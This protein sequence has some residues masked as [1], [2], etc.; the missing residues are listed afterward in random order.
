MVMGS[1]TASRQKMVAAGVPVV[2]VTTPIPTA[3]EALGIAEDIGYPVM[4][5]AAG[6]GGKG[7]RLLSLS[8][9]RSIYTCSIRSYIGFWRWRYHM[10]KRV[11]K[12]RHVEVQV[13]AD[14]HGNVSMFERDCS[15][16]RRHQKVVEEAP[17][18][19]IL[20]EVRTND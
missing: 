14:K 13:M 7:M 3:E 17:C 19:V 12:P 2:P 10:E 11:V 4:L 6:G 9:G 15:I 5:K 16:Q 8:I 20:P 18:P 1:K